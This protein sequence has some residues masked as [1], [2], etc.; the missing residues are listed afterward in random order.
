MSHSKVCCWWIPL[1]L[2]V[3]CAGVGHAQ[4]GG[5]DV[6]SPD[7]RIVL[8]FDVQLNK[9]QAAGEDGQL[10]YSVSFKGKQAFEESALRLELA[11]QAALGAAVHIAG[12]APGSGV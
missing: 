2:A 7:H 12:T 8:H 9:G 3:C 4:S 11:N 5:V 10:V 1:L 6:S